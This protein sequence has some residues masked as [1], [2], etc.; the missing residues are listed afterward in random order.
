MSDV[1]GRESECVEFRQ[2]RVCRYPR[3][4]R[5]EAG[6][7]AAQHAH[8]RPF[9]VVGGV[10]LQGSVGRCACAEVDVRS[11]D[12]LPAS[13]HF[14]RRRL[15]HSGARATDSRA[16]LTG[17]G[18]APEVGD[19]TGSGSGADAATR[20]SSAAVSLVPGSRRQSIDSMCILAGRYPLAEVFRSYG[21]LISR[22]G[23]RLISRLR[24]ATCQVVFLAA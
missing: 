6:E 21:S 12:V 20:A 3:Q 23:D 17:S 5:L 22:S 24:G 9:T 7:C 14:A 13:P 15:S 11:G 2:L 8:A 19:V 10:P 4:R 1:T 18:C 16:M